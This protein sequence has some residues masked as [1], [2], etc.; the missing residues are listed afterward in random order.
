MEAKYYPEW[1]KERLDYSNSQEMMFAQM[2]QMKFNYD[3]TGSTKNENMYQHWD[4]KFSHTADNHQQIRYVDVKSA[5]KK[6]PDLVAIE[7]KNNYGNEGWVFKGKG[8]NHWLCFEF[9]HYGEYIL[10]KTDDARAWVENNIDKNICIKGFISQTIYDQRI[11]VSR[12]IEG[13]K[14]QI[15]LMSYHDILIAGGKVISK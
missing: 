5:N 1:K 13:I 15:C 9:P 7:L 10:I 4:V 8:K 2:M 11:T 3:F 6:F 12:N 14:D